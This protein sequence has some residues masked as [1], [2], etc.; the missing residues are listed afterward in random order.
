M[1]ER[2]QASAGER[3]A[4]RHAA[5]SLAHD[6]Y[7][8][9]L[10][11]PRS[12]RDD[13]VTLAAYAGETARIAHAV[14]EPGLGAIRLQWWRD[15]IAYAVAG[16]RTGNPVA[17]A[18]TD[19]ARRRALPADLLELPLTGRERELDAG[20]IADETS[21]EDYLTETWGTAFRLA[22]RALGSEET[23]A[24][25]ALCGRSAAAYGRTR[26]A[27]DLPRHLAH[28]RLPLPPSRFPAHDP[29]DLPETEARAAVKA[30]ITVLAKE[31]REA[32]AEARTALRAAPA[33]VRPAFLPLALIEPYLRALESPG[34]DPLRDVADISPLVRVVRLWLANAGARV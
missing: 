23:E 1:G 5:R 24:M 22:A 14:S 13:L 16:V 31:A 6:W 20:S 15:A 17:D 7:L 4:V 11:A 32:L 26:V 25:R 29:R 19:M 27:L 9:A 33:A 30:A 3:E 8:A 10:L 18:L 28:G 21:F 12:V 2:A 34:H